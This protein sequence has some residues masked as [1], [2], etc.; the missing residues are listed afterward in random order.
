M[1]PKFKVSCILPTLNEAG[2]IE[3][4]IG[5]I[6]DVYKKNSFKGEIIVIDDSSPDGTWKIVQKIAKKNPNVKLIVRKVR[7]G[8]GAAT[9]EGYKAA[10]GD[11]IVSMESDLS[12]NPQDIPKLVN[13]IEDG[14]DIVAASRYTKGGHTNKPLFN[15]LLSKSGN[16]FVSVLFRIKI[17]DFTLHYRAFKRQILKKVNPVEKDGNPFLMEFIVKAKR[18]GFNRITEI[19]TVFRNREYGVSKNKVLGASIR[20]LKATLRIYFLNK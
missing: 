2:N 15:V 11:I 13:K 1:N 12:C 9:Y 3:K 10:S 14:Y 20:T 18:K 6:Q 5:E 8:A 19:P 16:K 4:L 7:D 17:S